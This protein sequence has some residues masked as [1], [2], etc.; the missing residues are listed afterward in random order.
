MAMARLRKFSLAMRLSWLFLMAEVELLVFKCR[1]IIE[2]EVK[3]R[4]F[5]F[6]WSSIMP[7]IKV[8]AVYV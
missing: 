7:P 3:V 6:K 5:V 1:P 2:V 4:L 8:P